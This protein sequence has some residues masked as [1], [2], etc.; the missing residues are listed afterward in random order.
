MSDRLPAASD[1]NGYNVLGWLR[2]AV[3]ESDN[4]LKGQFGYD[5][6]QTTLD[7]VVG[8]KQD[9]R[10]SLLSSVNCNLTG[11]AF[12]DLVAG[13]TDVKPFWEY[14][15]YNKKFEV[16]TAIYGKLSTHNWIQRGMGLN[17][18]GAVQYAL[19][20]GC[21]YFEPYWDSDDEVFKR[22]VL[23]QLIQATSDGSLASSQ[24]QGR[25]AKLV[26]RLL[27]QW[28]SPFQQRLF[29]DKARRDI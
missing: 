8:E 7:A 18:T 3:E 4:F 15:T 26:D 1:G 22:P 16:N 9:L 24:Q 28:G 19:A 13:L 2:E 5:K 14:R 10:S 17:F 6:I 11:K 23:A 27:G 29:G 21:S 20:G 25:A 12:T